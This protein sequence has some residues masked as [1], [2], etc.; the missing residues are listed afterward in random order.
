MAR[1]DADHLINVGHFRDN[2]SNRDEFRGKG[3]EYENVGLK[4]EAG[5]VESRLKMP[6][7]KPGCLKDS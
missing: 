4:K 2:F 5:S 6:G 1:M 7:A 3:D